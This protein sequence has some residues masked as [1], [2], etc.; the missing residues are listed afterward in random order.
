M[1]KAISINTLG[2]KIQPVYEP[3]APVDPSKVIPVDPDNLF[4]LL[5]FS[6]KFPWFV[7]RNAQ[8]CYSKFW[9]DKDTRQVVKEFSPD[10]RLREIN[11]PNKPLKALQRRITELLMGLPKH[12]ANF[13]YMKGKNI[14]MCAEEH[15]GCDVIIKMDLKDFFQSHHTA[16]I[17]RKLLELTKW[18]SSV[19]G[20]ISRICT[21]NG[22]MPQGAVSSPLLSIV[23]N[24]DM[25]VRIA[26]IAS[27]AGFTYTRYAD[28]VAFG[29]TGKSNKECWDFIRRI[30]EEF[31]P[32]KVNWDKVDV[33]R[34]SAYRFVCGVKVG[35]AE[36]AEI[37][38]K[39][40]L[41]PIVRKRGGCWEVYTHES[42]DKNQY[43]KMVSELCA[44]GIT[45]APK[46]YYMQDIQKVLGMNL[47]DGIKY[48]R[49]KYNDMRLQAL[50]VRK[51]AQGV[52]RQRFFGRLA[53][54]RSIDPKRAAIIDKILRKGENNNDPAARPDQAG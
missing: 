54:M 19:C 36:F 17:K 43:E 8:A 30:K 31:H 15:L 5:G 26:A 6:P 24:Y 50:L 46:Y 7:V 47:T 28:D 23:L 52:N 2:W 11:A 40:F 27:E 22:H 38:A 42:L 9:I 33:M 14:K 20:A 16:R 29:A 51:N 3:L 32:Y 18:P 41:K 37:A 35:S 12:P 53:F 13:A 48:P 49:A 34:N 39:R 4:N 1:P 10:L 25:D 44:Q 21:L 45:C